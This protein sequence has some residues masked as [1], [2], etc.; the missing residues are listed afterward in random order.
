MP[1]S[2]RSERTAAVAMIGPPTAAPASIA[3]PAKADC[4]EMVRWPRTHQRAKCSQLLKS[5]L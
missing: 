2:T 3:T 5:R 4:F 1:V